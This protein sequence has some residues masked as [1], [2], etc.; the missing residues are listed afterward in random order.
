MLV[1]VTNSQFT[2]VRWLANIEYSR[3]AHIINSLDGCLWPGGGLRFSWL[4]ELIYSSGMYSTSL[5]CSVSFQ[6]FMASYVI[7]FSITAVI[8][9]FA[10]LA[11]KN[12]ADGCYLK[13][14]SRFFSLSGWA[15]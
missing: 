1:L 2:K 5:L 10:V 8:E 3:A 15:W 12:N 14:S 11:S 6:V 7:F 13:T 9:K 4:S